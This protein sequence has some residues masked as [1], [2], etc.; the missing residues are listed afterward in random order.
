MRDKTNHAEVNGRVMVF[1]YTVALTYNIEC[2]QC[3]NEVL[4]KMVSN[5]TT[6]LL[7]SREEEGRDLLGKRTMDFKVTYLDAGLTS[8]YINDT[9]T[10]NTANTNGNSQGSASSGNSNNSTST[11]SSGKIVAKRYKT[12]LR[13]FLST[14]RSKRKSANWPWPHLNHLPQIGLRSGSNHSQTLMSFDQQTSYLQ[15]KKI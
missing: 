12:H 2:T 1:C 4:P 10:N 3:V 6:K 8:S 9:E 14:C 5:L 15:Q 11:N 7:L 13:D